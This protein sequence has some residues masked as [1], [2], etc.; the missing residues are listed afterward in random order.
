MKYV[1]CLMLAGCATFPEGMKITEPER[2]TCKTQ[3]CTVWTDGELRE[4]A[5]H[6]FR[7]GYKAGK[8]TL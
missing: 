7:E 6:F 1:L 2:E 8:S 4:V 3:G 5:K